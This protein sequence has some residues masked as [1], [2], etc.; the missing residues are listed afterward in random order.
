MTVSSS[1]GDTEAHCV[2]GS[3]RHRLCENSKCC[4]IR[5]YLDPYPIGDRGLQ[6]ILRDRILR[7]RFRAEFSHSLG[8]QRTLGSNVVVY[9]RQLEVLF[10]LL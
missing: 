9:G 1:K 7:T 4:R 5:G 8:T 3:K 6:R 10:Y 2:G